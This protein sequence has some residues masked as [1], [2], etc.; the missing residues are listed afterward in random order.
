MTIYHQTTYNYDCTQA[1]LE[2][3]ASIGG[4]IMQPYI[5]DGF[6]SET[7]FYWEPQIGRAHV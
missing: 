2:H 5:D 6:C 7:E 1:D 4:P 3:V